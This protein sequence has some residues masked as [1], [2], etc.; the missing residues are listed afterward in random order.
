MVEERPNLET[1]VRKA[2]IEQETDELVKSASENLFRNTFNHIVDEL[3]EEITQI[4]RTR[5]QGAEGEEMLSEYK[6]LILSEV[7]EPLED[8]ETLREIMNANVQNRY[9]PYRLAQYGFEQNARLL[10]EYEQASNEDVERFTRMYTSLL[11]IIRINDRLIRELTKIAKKEG[12]N[13]AVSKETQYAAIKK[14]FPTAESYRQFITRRTEVHKKHTKQVIITV[15]AI[16][17]EELLKVMADKISQCSDKYQELIQL[18]HLESKIK[19]I[20]GPTEPIKD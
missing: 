1:Q 5:V 18:H 17:G 15:A 20:Y 8:P 13:K 12:V 10:I 4:I 2:L 7:K 9:I 19:E 11:E 14:M 3:I 16:R 6:Q